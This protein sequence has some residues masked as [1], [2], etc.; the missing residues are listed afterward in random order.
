MNIMPKN[1]LRVLGFAYK[2]MEPKPLDFAD[3]SDLCFVG[4]V[5]QMD[6]PRQESKDAVEN[7]VLPVSNR[8]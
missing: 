3:E 5:A 6:P 1:G 8:S 2:N 4:M 7:V